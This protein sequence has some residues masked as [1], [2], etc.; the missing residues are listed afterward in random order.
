[1]GAVPNKT[2]KAPEGKKRYMSQQD[3]AHIAPPIS[4][5][6][7]V[8]FPMAS[9]AILRLGAAAAKAVAGEEIAV[10]GRVSRDAC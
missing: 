5:F 6:L 4:P 7:F 2:K 3:P 8:A 10:T 1:M 9:Y